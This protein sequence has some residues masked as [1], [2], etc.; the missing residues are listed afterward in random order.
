MKNAGAGQNMEK[1]QILL[2]D[3]D[4]DLRHALGQG[5]EIDGFDVRSFA[6][7]RDIFPRLSTGS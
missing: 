7:A 3:D 5:L 6:D 1:P 2:V 4:D